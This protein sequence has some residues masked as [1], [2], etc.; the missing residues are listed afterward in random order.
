M[1]RFLA[2]LSVMAMIVSMFSGVVLAAPG[3]VAVSVEVDNDV[4]TYAGGFNPAYVTGR[5][6]DS[7][8]GAVRGVD[9]T[10]LVVRD[11]D[12]DGVYDSDDGDFDVTDDVLGATVTDGVFTLSF[13][14]ADLGVGTYFVIGEDVTG[15]VFDYYATFTIMH[16]V[17]LVQPTTL[18][19]TWGDIPDTVIVQGM[20]PNED[21]DYEAEDLFL[22]YKDN[23]N[24]LRIATADFVNDSVFGFLF[25]GA[26]LNRTGELALYVDTGLYTG[27]DTFETD[28]DYVKK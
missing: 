5:I 18:E 10:L 11:G 13:T 17:E 24:T 16:A 25:D 4:V 23:P 9:T 26:A 2:T 20:F 8:T 28:A 19:W 22:A 7:E 14:T 1:K 3:D 12:G 21:F 27:G 6:V 15:Y